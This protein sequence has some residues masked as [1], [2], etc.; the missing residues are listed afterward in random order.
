MQ[1]DVLDDIFSVTNNITILMNYMA[2]Y[3]VYLFMK[4][5]THKSDYFLGMKQ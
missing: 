3:Y 1:F 5:W 4:T 2:I